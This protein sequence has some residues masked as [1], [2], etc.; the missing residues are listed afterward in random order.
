VG[1]VSNSAWPL[2]NLS[3][4]GFPQD[5]GSLFPTP[6]KGVQRT[7][8]F[9]RAWMNDL[10]TSEKQIT[11]SRLT[12][13]EDAFCADQP[14]ERRHAFW[15]SEE[16]EGEPLSLTCSGIASQPLLP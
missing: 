13:A 11:S 4:S 5:Q 15:N 14:E 16:G 3:L 10:I 6:F 7:W 12:Q 8:C 9:L 2:P 1:D